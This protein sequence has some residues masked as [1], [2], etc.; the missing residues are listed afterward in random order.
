MG[1]V[2]S[3]EIFRILLLRPNTPPSGQHDIIL[4][5]ISNLDRAWITQKLLFF[6]PVIDFKVAQRASHIWGGEACQK[7]QYDG[8]FKVTACGKMLKALWNLLKIKEIIG[9]PSM[10]SF[11]VIIH[12]VL[13]Y[14]HLYCSLSPSSTINITEKILFSP[15]FCSSTFLGYFTPS[16][17]FLPLL[18]AW[19]DGQPH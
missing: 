14:I 1:K 3:T 8:L 17:L 16:P 7:T 11:F 6:M 18:I 5:N 15:C 4:S 10:I 13:I 2:I 12:L 9:D 19:K